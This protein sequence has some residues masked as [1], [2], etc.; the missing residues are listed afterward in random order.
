MWQFRDA[1][2]LSVG[3]LVAEARGLAQN[4][5]C[6]PS[7]ERVTVEP[8]CIM[9]HASC[10]YNP[11]CF[12]GDTLPSSPGRTQQSRMAVSHSMALAGAQ[13]GPGGHARL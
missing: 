6:V 3:Q 1:A 7:L 12:I 10:S 4:G 9:H 8:S 11:V 2:Y 13:S 5:K